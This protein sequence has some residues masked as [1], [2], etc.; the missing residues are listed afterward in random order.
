[1]GK[2]IRK[3]SAN[4]ISMQFL[5]PEID[6]RNVCPMESLNCITS[7]PCNTKDIIKETIYR[8]DICSHL[9]HY[10]PYSSRRPRYKAPTRAANSKN[11]TISTENQ[12]F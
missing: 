1:M 7:I 10:T 12:Y 11:E 3:E 2:C 8:V 6:L 4:V 9:H 5:M